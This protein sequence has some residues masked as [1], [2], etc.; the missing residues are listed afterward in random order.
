MAL[1]GNSLLA[2]ANEAIASP[3]AVAMPRNL[4]EKN[5]SILLQPGAA[6]QL[7]GIST[8]YLAKLRAGG[9]LVE[10]EHYVRHGDRCYRYLSDRLYHWAKTR[11][12]RLEN[13]YLSHDEAAEMLAISVSFL[14]KLRANGELVEGVHYVRHGQRC[15]L[16]QAKALHS[17]ALNKN[18]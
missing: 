14:A 18:D 3:S 15:Y 7:I 5:Y 11:Q 1:P 4:A 8:S 9:D 16:Y 13:Q 17:W 2:T 10:G 6:A 12:Q